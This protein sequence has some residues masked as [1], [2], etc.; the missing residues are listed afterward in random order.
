MRKI[1]S[2]LLMCLLASAAWAYDVVF[3]ATVDLGTSDGNAGAFVIEKDC[4]T[5]D[6]S[7]G[8]A[9][10]VQYRFYKNK[11]VTISSECG[12]I[13]RVVF[14][15]VAE[16]TNQYGPG[17]FTVNV[18]DYSYQGKIGVWTGSSE[19]IVFTPSLNQVRVTRIIVTV[20]DACLSVPTIKPAGGTYYE[21]VTVEI[22]CPTQDAEIYYTLDGSDPTT[23]STR[24]TAPF[25]L[26]DNTTVK[27]IS[28]LDGEVS[29]VVT[30]EYVFKNTT[31]VL[32]ILESSL[33]DDGTVVRFVNPVYVLHQFKNYLF[34][35]DES[36]F[37]LFYGDTGQTYVNGDEIPAGFVGTMKT[38]ACERELSYLSGFNP[39]AGN[40]PIVP[41]EITLNRVGHETWAHYV[42]VRNVRL[43]KDENIPFIATDANGNQ[44]PVSFSMGVSAPSDLSQ[45]YDLIA[46]VGSHGNSTS[47]CDYVLLPVK[48]S[49]IFP[50]PPPVDLCSMDVIPDGEIVSFNV[51]T[52]VIYQSG[53]Y[54]YVKQGEYCYGLIYGNVGQTYQQGDMIPPGWSARKTTYSG[55]P[56]LTGPFE[57]F[58]PAVEN[59]PV[60]P[61]IIEIP[62]LGH[63]TWAHYVE[64]QDVFVSDVNNSTFTITDNY[65]YTCVGYSRFG[66][67]VEEGHYDALIG[68]VG[69]YGSTNLVYE[70][71]VTDFVSQPVP[72]QVSCLSELYEL[73][74]G[75]VAQ[76]V[77]P[78]VGIYQNGDY[79]YVKDSCDVVALVYGDIGKTFVNGDSI[80]GRASW[81]TYGGNKQLTFDG[82]WTV[83]GHGPE[84]E[85]VEKAIEELLGDVPEYVSIMGCTIQDD[86]MDDGTGE[87]LIY[88]KFE[89]PL[90]TPEKIS[91]PSQKDW[92]VPPIS[93]A[94]V[95][96]LIDLILRGTKVIEWDGTYD[97]TGFTTIFQNR[98]ELIPTRIQC[99]DDAVDYSAA[100]LNN[101]GEINIGDLNKLIEMILDQED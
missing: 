88:N 96:Y 19:V 2:L 63:E 4:V 1:L 34:V 82:E 3:D 49:G 44:C 62:D 41:E 37:G 77:V 100:D 48:L 84:V 90:P 56:E 91:F 45:T 16:G 98:L 69:S 7:Q 26:S 79:F 75:K 51:D 27:A 86:I 68:I 53:N 87:L 14:E 32:N 54:L 31:P 8:L 64:L 58:L 40:T 76:F 71:L 15:C 20:G 9:N 99:P 33:T 60:E 94:D 39:A 61:E 78:L 85:P 38:Y 12:P 30:A 24:Y 18:G 83:V 65:G 47:G 22:S 13:T 10:G 43:S 93:V 89:V 21:P 66:V 95:N 11:P 81:T 67:H 101:D 5:I 46:I 80:I 70:L 25:T 92:G 57:G 73:P 36:G 29:G 17:C 74:K 50:P 35:K 97:V 55:E 52:K 23:G 6:V 72:P 59:E 28:A 42:I